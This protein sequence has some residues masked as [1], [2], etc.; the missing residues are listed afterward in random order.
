MP[1]GGA[2]ATTA[3]DIGPGE[4]WARQNLVQSCSLFCRLHHA[5]LCKLPHCSRQAVKDQIYMLACKF[6]IERSGSKALRT[7]LS[8]VL[9]SRP[10]FCWKVFCTESK[11]NGRIR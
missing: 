3:V 6:Y 11:V 1:R 4:T 8:K 10:R 2:G 9:Y 5:C 7:P